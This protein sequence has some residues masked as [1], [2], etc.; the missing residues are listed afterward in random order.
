MSKRAKLIATA[1]IASLVVLMF[2]SLPIPRQTSTIPFTLEDGTT[3]RVALII[4]ETL[5]Q[6]DWAEIELDVAFDTVI[7][8]DQNVKIKT[9]LQSTGLEASPAGEV[10][11]VIPIEGIAPFRWRIR[12][13]STGE[14]HAT[15]WCFRQDEDDQ[16]L[17]LAREFELEVRS[18]LG[19]TFQFTRWLL[20][21]A[22]VLC[23]LVVICS[24]KNRN[25]HA[26][27]A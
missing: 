11:A 14:Q 1:G 6:G 13:T 21:T 5:R 17:I 26:V 16:K 24:V 8:L 22:A 4:P 23:A 19:T 3:G 20:G 27:S 15:I 2:I 12:S 25:K 9:I 18:F 10:S 7:T